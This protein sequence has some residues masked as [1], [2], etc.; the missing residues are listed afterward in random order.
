MSD[1]PT[2]AVERT[3]APEYK[4][5]EEYKELAAAMNKIAETADD[6]GTKVEKMTEVQEK[7]AEE[8]KKLRPVNAKEGPPPR[9][10]DALVGSTPELKDLSARARDRMT[11]KLITSQ[12]V[13]PNVPIDLRR[14]PAEMWDGIEEVKDLRD[15]IATKAAAS[16]WDATTSTS[17]SQW[18]PT[19]VGTDVIDFYDI[20][21][22]LPA[23][24]D[25]ITIPR[26]VR[27]VAVPVETTAA[28]AFFESENTAKTSP[29]DTF[30]NTNLIA[31]GIVNTCDLTAKKITNI[32]GMDM[33]ATEDVAVDM[34]GRARASGARVVRQGVDEA[35]INGQGSDDADL[36]DADTTSGYY[37]ANNFSNDD[38]DSGLRL[39]CVLNSLTTA[40]GGQVTATDILTARKDIG[41][42]GARPSELVYITS[43]KGYLGML[44]DSNVL[45]VEKYGDRATVVTGELAQVAG[46]PVV[47]SSEFSE[48]LDAA[49]INANAAT[50]GITGGVLVNR[51]RWLFGTGRSIEQTIVPQPGWDSVYV[52]SRTRVDF[53]IVVTNE[54]NARYLINVT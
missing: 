6:L 24:F 22:G 28:Y 3:P 13:A 10:I 1:E 9:T 41:K 18:A 33:V 44:A 37:A 51:S 38:G 50:T 42:Y 49:G 30:L 35:I 31:T 46:V 21:A 17:V 2:P 20:D 19:M 7:M 14:V 53:K 23:L 8:R 25:A 40:I 15:Q 16:W 4:A 54:A 47:I 29:V 45:T 5:S 39:H 34:L 11:L 52:V 43:P 12:A 32:H 27:T 48:D 36:D 26:G